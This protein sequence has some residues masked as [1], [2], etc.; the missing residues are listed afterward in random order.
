VLR[1]MASKQQEE[2]GLDGVE[3]ELI[4]RKAS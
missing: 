3:A 2:I 4:T 1:N